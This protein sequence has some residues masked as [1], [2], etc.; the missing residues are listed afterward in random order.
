MKIQKGY[1]FKAEL[2]CEFKENQF[3]NFN[4]LFKNCTQLLANNAFINVW[5]S[6]IEPKFSS[7]LLKEHKEKLYDELINK[8]YEYEKH[9]SALFKKTC[10]LRTLST[11]F[12]PN[13][14]PLRAR[15]LTAE[16]SNDLALPLVLEQVQSLS[17]SAEFVCK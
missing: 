3:E 2:R 10:V 8:A 12:S 16:L 11:D 1:E 6:K 15:N 13:L 9:Y 5:A 14:K 17:A 4:K 7:S